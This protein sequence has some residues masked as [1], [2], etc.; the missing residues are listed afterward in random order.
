MMLKM[1]IFIPTFRVP[2][3]CCRQIMTNGMQ[4]SLPSLHQAQQ[5]EQKQACTMHQDSLTGHQSSKHI[6][7]LMFYRRL[8]DS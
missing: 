7:V 1:N 2:L 4:K 6:G 5:I 8:A 3:M